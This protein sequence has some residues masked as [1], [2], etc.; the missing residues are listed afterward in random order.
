MEKASQITRTLIE[1][2]DAYSQLASLAE[3][4]ME[5]GLDLFSCGPLTIGATQKARLE[6]AIILYD[7]EFRTLRD[8]MPEEHRKK[9]NGHLVDNAKRVQEFSARAQNL[10][11]DTPDLEQEIRHIHN[12]SAA[13]GDD[14]V[15]IA[16]ESGDVLA[17]L[18][19]LLATD[20]ETQE[21]KPNPVRRFW[22]WFL[23]LMLRDDCQPPT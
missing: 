11:P 16:D 13:I 1:A 21:K 6:L 10:E 15:G 23:R 22:E 17:H 19:K 4:G 18:D 12:E 8:L 14:V 2:S 20:G 7:P 9:V 5:L 3:V